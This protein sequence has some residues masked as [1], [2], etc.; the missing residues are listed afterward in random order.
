MTNKVRGRWSPSRE[1]ISLAIDCSRMP[2][3][4]A[5]ELIGVGPRTLWLFA[6]R[7][8][9]PGLDDLR[10]RTSDKRIKAI[11]ILGGDVFDKLLI[12][13]ALRPEFPKA[14]FFTTEV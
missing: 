8:G 6:K 9:L 11:G 13:R 1:Q 3:T 10:K 5:A 14:L 2:I 4:R 12:L 7:V